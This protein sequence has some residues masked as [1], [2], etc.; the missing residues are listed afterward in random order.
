MWCWFM[1]RSA[2]RHLMSPGYAGPRHCS[3]GEL[4]TVAKSTSR[5]FLLYLGVPLLVA[6]I[7]A[8]SSRNCA[9]KKSAIAAMESGERARRPKS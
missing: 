7:A 9:T 3:V 2:T 1:S 5:H 6:S 8:H 4:E